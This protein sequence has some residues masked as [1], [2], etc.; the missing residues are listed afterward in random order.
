MHST[1]VCIMCNLLAGIPVHKSIFETAW[2]IPDI[3]IDNLVNRQKVITIFLH[4]NRKGYK[5]S[6]ICLARETEQNMENEHKVK[7]RYMYCIS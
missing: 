6:N 7:L 5:V 1:L 4:A 3:Q 2:T